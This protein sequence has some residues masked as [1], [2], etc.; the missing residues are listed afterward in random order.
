MRR[1]KRGIPEQ[2]AK[3]DNPVQR[4]SQFMAQPQQKVRFMLAGHPLGLRR[5]LEFALERRADTDLMLKRRCRLL[6]ALHQPPE[7][8]G[9]LNHPEQKEDRRHRLTS[10]TDPGLQDRADLNCLAA[11][12]QDR[13]NQQKDEMDKVIPAPD[14]HPHSDEAEFTRNSGKADR[15]QIPGHNEQR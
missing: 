13:T 5:S 9:Q 2:A 3:P 4:G 14:R 8:P 10:P 7:S 11:V 6:E 12:G 1:I 15:P